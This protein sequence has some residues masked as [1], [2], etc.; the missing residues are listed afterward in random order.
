[1]APCSMTLDDLIPDIK[2]TPLF[3]F[4]YD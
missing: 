4:Y 1:M 2:G 3:D